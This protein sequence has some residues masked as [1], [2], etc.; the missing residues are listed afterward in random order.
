MF[1]C[2]YIILR[3]EEIFNVFR[4]VNIYQNSSLVHVIE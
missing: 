3:L 2:S 1:Q 4:A